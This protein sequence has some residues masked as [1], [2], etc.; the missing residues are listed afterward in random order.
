MSDIWLIGAGEMAIEYSKVL[1][2]L[3][4][5]YITIGRGLSSAKKYKIKTKKD[6]Y[7]GGLDSF[8][9]DKPKKVEDAIVA[10]NVVCLFDT[11]RSLINYGIKNILIEKPAG[12]N[13]EEVFLLSDLASKHDVNVFIAYNRRFYQSVSMAKKIIKDDGGVKSFSFDFTE[14]IYRL[15]EF[16]IPLKEKQ[17]LVLNNSS[18]VMDLAFFIG[19]APKIIE[20]FHNDNSN[21]A[22]HQSASIFCGAGISIDGSLFSYKSNWESPGRWEL[23]INTSK[24]KLVFCPLE[25]LRVQKHGSFDTNIHMF[26]DPKNIDSKFKPGLFMLVES[27][28]NKKT[29]NICDINQMKYMVDIYYQIANY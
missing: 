28:L 17:K 14:L 1:E 26:D 22:W 20:C 24:H 2:H 11:A 19:G 7:V 23:I 9:L 5:K 16:S 27:F 21:L 25:E 4:I 18:H 8:L 15:N 3:N 13:R 29:K 10:V 6:A 12:L